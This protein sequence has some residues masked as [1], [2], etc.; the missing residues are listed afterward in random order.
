MGPGGSCA[1]GWQDG[2]GCRD[3]PGDTCA[4]HRMLPVHARRALTEST[5]STASKLEQRHPRD[6][7]TPGAGL[8]Q[9]PEH[10][11]TA[12]RS[13]LEIK[14]GVMIEE[15]AAVTALCKQSLN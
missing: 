1:L 6:T 12:K 8:P 2:Q 13:L 4:H 5:C 9:H 3:I 11:K 14:A 7:A 10:S 15:K